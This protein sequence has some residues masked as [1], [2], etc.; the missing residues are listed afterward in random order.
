M[1]EAGM[2]LS[3]TIE[4][5]IDLMDWCRKEYQEA[6]QEIKTE[7][8]RLQDFLHAIEFASDKNERN[9]LVTKLRESRIRRR[10]GKDRMLELEFI[11]QY[12]NNPAHNKAMN[13]LKQ[14]L[15][16]QRKREAYLKG[17]RK[18]HNR[19]EEEEKTIQ[20]KNE[21]GIKA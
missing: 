17:D 16:N 6:K 20:Q 12:L 19:V 8:A 5:I 15:E 1:K 9:R 10:K 3:E 4:E 11:L 7:D 14:L 2:P 13:G 21:G 18:Y